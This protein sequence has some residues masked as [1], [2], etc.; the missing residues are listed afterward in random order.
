MGWEGR[1][2]VAF[3]ILPDGRVRDIRVVRGSGHAL[4]DRSAVEA[5]RSASPFPPPPA[6]AEILTPVVFKLE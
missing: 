3:V 1:V 5:V 6:E 4:L 2:V